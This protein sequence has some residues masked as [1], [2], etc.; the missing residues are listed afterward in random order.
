[1]LQETVKMHFR[2][3]ATSEVCA[4]VPDLREYLLI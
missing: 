4:L 1:M 2:L 3:K